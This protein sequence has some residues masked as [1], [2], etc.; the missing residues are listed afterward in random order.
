MKITNIVCSLRD[1]SAS[2]SGESESEILRAARLSMDEICT[3]A[4]VYKFRV[5]FSPRR[6]HAK[7][8]LYITAASEQVIES[9]ERVYDWLFT[10][11]R[12]G[13]LWIDSP[14]LIDVLTL[15]PKTKRSNVSGFNCFADAKQWISAR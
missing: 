1:G 9:V 10:A 3:L 2:I 13:S 12:A 7:F 5:D 8:D 6:T 15:D 11:S 14:L 4:N